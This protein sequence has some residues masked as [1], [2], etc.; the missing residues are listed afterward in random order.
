[1][2]YATERALAES[3]IAW[4]ILRNSLYAEYQ[5]PEAER[6]IQSGRLVHNRGDG[7]VA[8]VSRE[9]CARAAVAVLA[10]GGHTNTVYDITGPERYG[11]AELARLYGELGGCSI[12]NVPLGDED[13]VAGM[14]G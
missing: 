1:S 12:E 6:A 10:A 11:A 4:T 7:K 13:F 8:Y 3:G 14:V 2:H 9:D 5:A